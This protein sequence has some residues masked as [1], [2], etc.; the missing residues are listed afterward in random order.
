M[1]AFHKLK[2]IVEYK[3]DTQD[4]VLNR[5]QY[6]RIR[7]LRRGRDDVDKPYSDLYNKL[8][9]RW[10]LTSGK[11]KDLGM[12]SEFLLQIGTLVPTEKE[13][14]ETE[15]K[16]LE[17]LEGQVAAHLGMKINKADLERA[18]RDFLKKDKTKEEKE[19]YLRVENKYKVWINHTNEKQ[20]HM[21]ELAKLDLLV[22][23]HELKSESKAKESKVE[24]KAPMADVPKQFLKL[25]DGVPLFITRYQQ[26]LSQ[27]SA[28]RRTDKSWGI[29]DQAM[30]H[31]REAKGLEHLSQDDQFRHKAAIFA[32]HY[33]L[34]SMPPTKKSGNVARGFPFC[35]KSHVT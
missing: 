2:K 13:A 15:E 9:T 24:H 11:K 6:A 25:E 4:D 34:S 18:F 30:K 12:A 28:Q 5:F 3:A 23:H 29:F 31:A 35:K 32:V 16:H 14:N 10:S 1:E 19:A 8:D 27:L 21:Y 33:R 17:K 20:A 22:P 7:A 26:A